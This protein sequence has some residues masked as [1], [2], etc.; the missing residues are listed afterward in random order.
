MIRHDQHK[1]MIGLSNTI[2][3]TNYKCVVF[4]LTTRYVVAVE[5]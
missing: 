1:S 2:C 3:V 4:D 5:H